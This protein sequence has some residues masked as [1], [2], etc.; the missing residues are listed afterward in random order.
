MEDIELMRA[1]RNSNENLE[2]VPEWL[3]EGLKGIEGPVDWLLKIKIKAGAKKGQ[4]VAFKVGG[5]RAES[6]YGGNKST[7]G[8]EVFAVQSVEPKANEKG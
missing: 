5:D 2:G 6:Q 1:L 3:A 4:K 8:F 7:G